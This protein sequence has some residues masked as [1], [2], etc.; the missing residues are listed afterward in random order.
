MT[1]RW[2][3]F[4]CIL[5]VA[6]SMACTAVTQRPSPAPSEPPPSPTVTVAVPTSTLPP[7]PDPEL[8]PTATIPPV[9]VPAPTP[10]EVPAPVPTLSVAHRH[11]ALKERL[12]GLLNVS[13]EGEGLRPL[14]LGDNPAAQIHADAN[15]DSCVSSHW[16][17]DGTTPGMRY[18]LAGGHQ[19]TTENISGLDYCAEEADGYLRIDLEEEL[20]YAVMGWMQSP[21]HRRAIMFP[22]WSK[23]NIGLAWSRYQ[24]WAVV[25]FESDYL[26]YQQAPILDNGVLRFSG[27][28]GNG[29]DL[30]DEVSLYAEV[31]YH[32]PLQDLT[33]GQLARTYSPSLGLTVALLRRPAP[34]GKYWERDVFTGTF[35]PACTAPSEIP[36]D[37]SPPADRDEA[38]RLWAAA[39][40]ECHAV[41]SG[42]RPVHSVPWVTALVWEVQDNAFR[43]EADLRNVLARH[44]PG[45]YSVLLETDEPDANRRFFISRY[46][47]PYGI[48]PPSGYGGG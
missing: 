13:R 8:R 19:N 6:L 17:Q 32:P 28:V 24:L 38:V 1:L 43:V 25:Q 23:L 39:Q 46:F 41:K 9:T 21:G 36:P 26:E 15:R 47:I 2:L 29:L 27:T 22:H 45:M 44:G 31:H 33:R 10:T 7:Q 12:V 5:V 18:T 30:A 11:L 4:G 48:E 40:D 14:V 16:G 3:P 34:E 35:P 42:D 20:S 37:A